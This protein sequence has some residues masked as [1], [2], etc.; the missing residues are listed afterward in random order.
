MK[1][2]NIVAKTLKKN[3][4]K[5]A[6]GL[7][8]GAVVHIFDS[9]EAE[10]F[11]VTYCHHEESASLAAVA[12]AKVT[13]S[14]GCVVVTSGPGCT[15]A[16]TGLLAA[17]QD[18][19]PCIFLSGQVRS[20]HV[21]YGKKIRQLGTQE[22][23]ILEIVKPIVKKAF[24][25]DDKEKVIDIMHEAIL[26]SLSGRPGP[27]WIDIPLDYQWD[28]THVGQG[29]IKELSLNK[30][31]LAKQDEY[32][33]FYDLMD[34]AI[35]PLFVLGYGVRLS[36]SLDLC[37]QFIEKNS[38]DFVTTWTAADYFPTDHKNNLG[39]IGMRGQ[40]G[41]NKA[42][43][44][45][46]LVICLGT[47]L[48]IPHTTTL[49]ETFAPNSKKVIINIDKD[50]LEELNI[51]FDL[52][53]HEDLE[54]FLDKISTELSYK[55]YKTLSNLKQLNWYS[56]YEEIRPNPNNF[57]RQLTKASNDCSA[58]IIDGGGT[59][60]YA[61]F[62]SAFIKEDQ[63]IICSSSISAMGTG[64]AE[65][66]GVYN[67]KNFT[68]LIC[69]IGDGSFLMNIQ[70][71]QTIRSQNIP[72]II[73]VINNNGYLAIRNTQNE[74]LEGKLYG[75]HPDWSLEM[76]NIEKLSKGFEI[77]Y[78]KLDNKLDIKDTVK[79]LKK[80]KGPVICEV[81]VEEDVKELFSQGYS[82]N[83]D[84]TFT[85]LPLYEMRKH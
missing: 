69:I 72:V 79:K 54:I 80:E 21:S 24:L 28:E 2:T 82:S 33:K 71:L 59:A 11:N 47:H 19:V 83:D 61:G 15:N 66:I 31:P 62:Q 67:S 81:I 1:L 14:P 37:K 68:N 35:S 73:C 64:L 9:L 8:G 30:K 25:L 23:P 27:V 3:G 41:A 48:S 75:T 44:E 58:F 17:W 18:S 20:S 52:K 60:L 36:H 4:I 39:I 77:P 5:D 78:Y 10:G 84:G 7:Q 42:I 26:E 6:F 56:P 65:T 63:R 43:F 51:E 49:T 74:F 57:F 55:E 29:D 53:I 38:L 16:I 32:K 40:E 22:V 46:D 34:Q 45:S 70:D 76:P 13:D 50:Q 12:N 85:P